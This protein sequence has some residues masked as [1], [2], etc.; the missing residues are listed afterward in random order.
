MPATETETADVMEMDVPAEKVEIEYEILRWV[1]GSSEN[2]L[3]LFEHE[4]EL[5]RELVRV[6]R[7]EGP[8]KGFLHKVI[9]DESMALQFGKEPRLTVEQ[10]KQL[11]DAAFIEPH[12]AA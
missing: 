7:H 9:F 10:V 1:G 2:Q 3:Y 5:C 4:Y 6:L 8:M 11:A 12:A